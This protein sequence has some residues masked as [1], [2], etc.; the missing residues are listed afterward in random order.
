MLK[1]E[2]AASEPWD[3]K[4][5]LIAVLFV[6]VI[7]FAFL[8]VKDAFFPDK[9][10][11]VKGTFSSRPQTRQDKEIRKA[12]DNFQA[13]LDEIQ[14]NLKNLNAVDIATSTPQVQKILNDIGALQNLPRDQARQACE[15]ICSGL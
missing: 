14:N 7:F 10:T 11:S 12:S 15:K 5:I 3:R 1:K 6:L 13:K 2:D 4:K 8:Y 9:K